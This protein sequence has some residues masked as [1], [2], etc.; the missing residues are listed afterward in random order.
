M[1]EFKAADF[2]QID[3]LFTDEE[4]MARDSVREWVTA[5]FMPVIEEHNRA[6][7]FPTDLI[8]SLGEMGVL[9]A[10][11]K[12]YDC[13]GMS[14]VAYGLVLQELERG[15]SGL[16]SF[17]SVQGSL[18]M[19]PIYAYGDEEQK[20]KYLPKM[21]AGELIG[22]FGLT[23][24]DFGSDPGGMLTRAVEDGDSYVLN[25]SKF[26]ITNGC[27]ADVAIV[28]AKLDGEVRGF[29]IDKGT[30]GF[31]TNTI[32][33]KF[34]L[35][36]SV[37]SEL[38]F[39]DCRI[40]KSNIL[41]NV[42]GLKGPLGCLN[43]ARY[44]IAFGAVGAAMAVY[45]EA[46]RYAKNRIQFERPIA[47]FQLVQNKLVW[48]VNEITKAQL[49]SWRLGRLKESG[50]LHHSHVSL[51]KR[52]SCWMALECCRL[53]RDILGANG[54]TDEYQTMR[55]M[56]NLESVITY[57]GTHDIHALIVGREITGENA[58]E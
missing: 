4:R 23:E 24:A 43:Q 16:R 5:E 6:G 55:H 29:L 40:P 50:R 48:M 14:P 36:A 52:N 51:A 9:G 41:P 7:T 11:L 37:T 21:A 47:R 57:E 45:D 2:Y 15:D 38:V 39:E 3:D 30:P 58:I 44:G 54:I 34:S 27:I 18:C 56:C 31:S 32:K 8:P 10:S 12:G 22:C 20:Q 17:V 19:Y 26:W 42:S 25:G 28:W 49:Q 46:L 13:A 53:A 33:N 1:S 35:R